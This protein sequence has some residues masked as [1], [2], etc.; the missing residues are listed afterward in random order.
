MMPSRKTEITPLDPIQL[1]SLYM[2]A[3]ERVIEAGFASEIDWQ[4]DASLDD[5][6]ERIFLRESAWVVLATGFREAV[7]RRRFAKVSQAFLCWSSADSIVAQRETCR[8]DA[9]AAF[10]NERKIDA[11]IGIAERVAS[12]GIDII[13][14]KIAEQGTAFLQEFPY[15]GPVTSCHLAKNLGVVMVKPDRHLTRMAR[16]TGYQSA[17]H[18]CR[19]ISDVV[20]D[21]LSVIDIVLWR[22]ATIHDWYEMHSEGPDFRQP[23]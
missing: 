12:E 3:K 17:D 11:I 9:L 7:L 4:E 5:L 21:S 18:M 20:G 13:R 6:D 14:R 19:R 8:S 22:Y 23:Q 10:A 2:S 1:A 16:K 15:L